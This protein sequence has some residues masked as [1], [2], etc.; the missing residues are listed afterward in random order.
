MEIQH[1]DDLRLCF[2]GD[3][4][5]HGTNDPEYLGWTGRVSILARQR[6]YQLTCYNLGV[7]RDTSS[8]IA[9]CWESEAERRLPNSC[10]PYL[11]Y[12]YGVNDT[13]IEERRTRVPELVSIENTRRIMRTARQCGYRTALIGPPPIADRQHNER[14]RQL[15][16]VMGQVAVAEGV[17]FLSTFDVLAKDSVW[18]A[19]VSSGDGAHPS[20]AGYAQFAALVDGWECWWF[21]K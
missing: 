6:G 14:T 19:E 5:V 11:I 10:T 3:S 20:A 15:S 4:F 16:L 12:S 2:V 1:T 9:A 18:M 17:P 7:R 13:M 8:D 21:R